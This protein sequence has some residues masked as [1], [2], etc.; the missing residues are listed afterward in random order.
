VALGFGYQ[1]HIWVVDMAET[2]P[3]TFPIDFGEEEA[4]FEGRE[5]IITYGEGKF[6]SFGVGKIIIYKE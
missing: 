2:F 1:V 6:I 5:G 4:P 3:L